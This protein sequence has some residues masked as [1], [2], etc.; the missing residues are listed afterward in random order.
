MG[1]W[2]PKDYLGSFLSYSTRY[3]YDDWTNK[4]IFQPKKKVS[5][6]AGFDSCRLLTRDIHGHV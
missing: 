3:Y 2:V 1:Q 5:S 6:T 4:Q